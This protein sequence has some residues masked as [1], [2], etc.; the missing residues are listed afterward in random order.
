MGKL[1]MQVQSLIRGYVR[2]GGKT[3]RRQQ[4]ARMVEFA[5]FCEIEGAAD[6]GCVGARHVI[7]YWKQRRNLARTTLYNHHRALCVLWV[8]SRKAGQPPEPD[9]HRCS[10]SCRSEDIGQ[11]KATRHPGGC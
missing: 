3:N 6:M 4:A 11:G 10:G 8:L 9:Y 1:V 2:K 7:R 5:R